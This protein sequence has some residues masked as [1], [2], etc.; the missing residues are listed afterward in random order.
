MVISQT[1]DWCATCLYHDRP[2]ALV[3]FAAESHVD[4]SIQG[5]D[6][7]IR[8][9]VNGTFSLLEETRDYWASSKEIEKP[10]FAF[11]T[12]QPTRFTAH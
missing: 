1:E 8:T 11:C 3:H 4:R 10:S 12:F 6:S 5:P 7:F 9:N 2:R